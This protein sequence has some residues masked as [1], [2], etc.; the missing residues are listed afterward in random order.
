M[1]SSQGIKKEEKKVDTDSTKQYRAP[2]KN[3]QSGA[4]EANKK[5]LEHIDLPDRKGGGSKLTL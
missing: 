3:L 5:L 2:E 4:K 1:A